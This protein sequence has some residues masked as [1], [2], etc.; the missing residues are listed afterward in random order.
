MVLR[1]D[2]DSMSPLYPDGS[3]IVCRGPV[4]QAAVRDGWDCVVQTGEGEFTFKRV[5]WRVKGRQRF[6]VT[7]PVNHHYC[8][9]LYLPSEAQVR[10]VALTRIGG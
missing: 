1:V 8:P 9:E 10:W 4:D 6:L 5:C 2:G 3:H 7:M